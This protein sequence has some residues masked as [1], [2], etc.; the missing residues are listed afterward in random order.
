M[1]EELLKLLYKI[2]VFIKQFHPMG[3][4]T[5]SLQTATQSTAQTSKQST[6]GALDLGGASTQITFVP[7]DPKLIVAGDDETLSLYG[8]TY[9]VYTHSYLCYGV[10]EAYRRHLANL[11]KVTLAVYICIQV[12]GLNY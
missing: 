6:F 5:T 4:I 12:D 1:I 11:V 3:R 8:E 9:K 2:Y 10:N 7:E